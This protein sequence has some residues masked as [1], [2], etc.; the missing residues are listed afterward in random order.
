MNIT[1][2]NA[3]EGTVTLPADLNWAD[4]YSW[5]PAVSARDYTQ[6]G[7][8]EIQHGIRQKG[9]PITLV[10]P[11]QN[12]GWV[13]KT[14]VTALYNIAVKSNVEYT[15]T[16]FDGRQFKVMFDHSSTPIEAEPL[17][18]NK[19]DEPEQP[20]LVTIRLFEVA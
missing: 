3:V 18:F 16:L 12:R 5:V 19:E 9:R 20:H 15:L 2:S 8:L 6:E 11:D 7:V 14:D 1:I 13:P 17:Y 4:E 10:S